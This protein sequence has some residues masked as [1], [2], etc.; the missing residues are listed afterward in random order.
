MRKQATLEFSINNR[1]VS[2]STGAS[3]PKETSPQQASP[4]YQVYIIKNGTQEGPI[5]FDAV[6]QLLVKGEIT[7]DTLLWYNGLSSWIPVSQLQNGPNS[8]QQPAAALTS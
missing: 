7:P 4:K 6:N 8:T 3:Q 2:G 5:T 1:I